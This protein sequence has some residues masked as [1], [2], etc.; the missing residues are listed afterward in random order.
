MWGLV[1]RDL[2]GEA[3][4]EE[5]VTVAEWLATRPEDAGLVALVKGHRARIEGRAAL[6]VDTEGALRRVR[7]RIADDRRTTLSVSDGG[8]PARP[9]APRVAATEPRTRI[10]SPIGTRAFPLWRITAAVAAAALVAIVGFSQWRANGG[11]DANEIASVTYRTA[12]G[13]TDTLR[14]PDGSTIILAPGS[15]LTVAAGYGNGARTVA[16]D[17]AAFF[18]VEHDEARPFVV[19][20]SNAEVRDLGTAFSVRTG[21][22]G[23]VSVA[24][25]HGIVALQPLSSTQ[26]V[27]LR[28]GD[29]GALTGTTV[30]V[31]RGVVTEED[32]S[33]TRGVMS[34]R[35]TPLD[36]VQGDLFRWYGKTLRVTDPQLARRTLTASFRADSS[37][38]A[39]RLIA[40]A[41]GA[42]AEVRGDTVFLWPLGGPTDSASMR[43]P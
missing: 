7:E 5:S 31:S 24:V 4:A 2:A 19:R 20:V 34:Y 1:A 16:L 42:D 22:S 35:D 14:L 30:T 43:R 3:T 18:E 36:E 39:I 33:W 15:A 12:T 37:A 28:A 10:G 21:A 23:A 13:I 29:H 32:V 40:L 38:Q 27:E 8:L 17:G 11:G 26:R 41:I 9:H 25:T 6:T